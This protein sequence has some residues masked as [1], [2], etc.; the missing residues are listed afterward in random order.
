MK[1]FKEEQ[2]CWEIFFW[3]RKIE[4]SVF[5]IFFQ[6]KK[7]PSKK[8]KRKVINQKNWFFFK[9]ISELKFLLKQSPTWEA[10]WDILCREPFSSCSPSGNNFTTQSWVATRHLWIYLLQCNF[11]QNTVKPIYIQQA[12]QTQTTLRAANATKT[13]KRV[14]KVFKLC[15]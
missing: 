9:K 5:K 15:F 4:S 12:C 13:D 6:S 1:A 10:S 8:K 2:S 7:L 3:R 14:A 11:L